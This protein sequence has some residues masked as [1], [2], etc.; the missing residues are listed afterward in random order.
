M[1]WIVVDV[2]L[3][4]EG[5]IIPGVLFLCSLILLFIINLVW[6]LSVYIPYIKKKDAFYYKWLKD[7]PKT[8]L[9][10]HAFSYIVCFLC[11]RMGL[12]R[13]LTLEM[14]SG[15]LH[16]ERQIVRVMN[17]FTVVYLT[18]VCIPIIALNIYSIFALDLS[19]TTLFHHIECWII[20]MI[21]AILLIVEIATG[22]TIN[23]FDTFMLKTAYEQTKEILQRGRSMM[24]LK[25]DT[26]LESK[27]LV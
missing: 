18:L 26:A 21:H 5:F 24:G 2:Y 23:K 11:F 17:I 22:N 14:F 27:S 8:E 4:V 12:T 3:Y 20:T 7:Y 19:T 25:Q 13:F 9:F 1:L 15:S 16:R 6:G 10:N